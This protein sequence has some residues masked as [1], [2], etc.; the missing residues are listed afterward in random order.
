SKTV[1]SRTIACWRERAGL[2]GEL[3]HA[4]R[5]DLVRAGGAACVAHARGECAQDHAKAG[6]RERERPA[7]EDETRCFE[8]ARGA[9]GVAFEMEQA[10]RE[11]AQA[12]LQ[13]IAVGAA[14][15]R[16]GPSIVWA[17]Q[18]DASDLAAAREDQDVCD[19]RDASEAGRA[20]AEILV[21][22]VATGAIVL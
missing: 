12:L 18:A 17:L 5:C 19:H 9:A 10:A 15:R 1:R 8:F 6:A 16:I 14:S 21:G 11:F 22:G 3:D 7:T 13:R 20:P 4:T 2:S